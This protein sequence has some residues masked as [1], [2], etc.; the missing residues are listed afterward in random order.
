[1]DDVFNRGDTACLLLNY[2]VNGSAMEQGAYQEIELQLNPQNNYNSIKKLL[3]KNEIV[4]GENFEY[5]D[6]EGHTQSFTGYVAPL[7]QKDT[8][9]LSKGISSVQ[10]RVMLNNDVGSSEYSEID[11]GNSLSSKVLE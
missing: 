1:M 4:W 10:L 7:T 11:I 9:A 5:V 3:S 8:F 6:E 2:T